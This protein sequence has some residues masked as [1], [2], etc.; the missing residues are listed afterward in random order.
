LRRVL[1]DTAG[2]RFILGPGL[3][4][5]LA[6][7]VPPALGPTASVPRPPADCGSAGT[8]GSHAAPP[9]PRPAPLQPGARRPLARSAAGAWPW[10]P[11]RGVSPGSTRFRRRR[12]G[13]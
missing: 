3:L 5:P 8:A 6:V 1:P 10:Q 9:P 7:G 4:R 12:R 11:E 2:E 13:G